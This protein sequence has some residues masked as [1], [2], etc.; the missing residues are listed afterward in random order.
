MPLSFRQVVGVGVLL[1]RSPSALSC[2][3]NTGRRW[4]VAVS[5]VF[6]TLFQPESVGEPAASRG[7]LVGL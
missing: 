6:F 4:A 3:L 1:G 2:F 7:P 5:R